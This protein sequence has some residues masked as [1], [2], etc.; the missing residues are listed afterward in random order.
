[1][2][3]KETQPASISDSDSDDEFFDALANEESTGDG[4]ENKTPLS[5][6]GDDN[7]TM[8]SVE[9]CTSGTAETAKDLTLDG[10]P[11][12]ENNIDV[13]SVS[14]TEPSFEETCES[15]PDRLTDTVRVSDPHGAGD[16]CSSPVDNTDKESEH[17]NFQDASSSQP[18]SSGD[19]GNENNQDGEVYDG[20]KAEEDE[21]DG[22]HEEGENKEEEEKEEDKVVD[23]MEMRK[24]RED[25]MTDE[26]REVC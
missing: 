16:A 21:D 15:I 17:S 14:K 22:L 19:Q 6:D 13:S 26:E 7:P 18:F 4:K 24:E 20:L 1:M 9:N 23:E 12:Q 5:N 3:S 2:A 11:E 25:A 10:R 8:Q